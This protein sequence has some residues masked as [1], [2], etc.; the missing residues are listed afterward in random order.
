MHYS[1]LPPPVPAIR[2]SAEFRLG[3]RPPLSRELGRG[4]VVPSRPAEAVRQGVNF[5]VRALRI[6][7]Q[8]P[9][10]LQGAAQPG[11]LSRSMVASTRRPNPRRC[12][13]K[14]V[15]FRY[16]IPASCFRTKTIS[17]FPASSTVPPS[18]PVAGSQPRPPQMHRFG[19]HVGIFQATSGVE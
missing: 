7:L 9:R 1:S 16:W 4:E 2:F 6:A 8:A 15:V 3:C 17:G 11:L 18:Y 5:G 12:S 19:N 10:R 14:I 13:S